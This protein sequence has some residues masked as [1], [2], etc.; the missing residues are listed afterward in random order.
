MG[1]AGAGGDAVPAA[2]TA[3]VEIGGG[4]GFVRAGA[5]AP[6]GCELVVVGA[7]AEA[8][9]GVGGILFTAPGFGGGGREPNCPLAEAIG[10][11]GAAV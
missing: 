11:G 4:G 10:G 7:I 9:V 3:V 2:I 5:G 1:D 6:N 8:G